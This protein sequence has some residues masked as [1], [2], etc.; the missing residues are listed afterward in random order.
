MN[1]LNCTKETKNPKFCSRSC[2]AKINNK[3]RT[4]KQRKYKCRKCNNRVSY[5]RT[6]CITCTQVP[7]TTLQEAMYLLHHKS[8]AYA[9]VRTR[10]RAIMKNENKICKNCGYSKHVEVCHIIP[11][12]SFSPNTLLSVINSKNNL[13]LLCP[14]CH[15]EFDR[16]FLTLSG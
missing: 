12:S 4:R 3:N 15:W 2:S 16:G 14:N 9:L 10:A 6:T 5:K 8:S 1:C 11:I 13:I 7:A